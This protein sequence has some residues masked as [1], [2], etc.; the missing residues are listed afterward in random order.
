MDNLKTDTH[1]VIAP[2]IQEEQQFDSRSGNAVTSSMFIF[3][4]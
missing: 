1:K 3:S 2:S 4:S